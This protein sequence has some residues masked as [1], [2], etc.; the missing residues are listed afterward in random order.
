MMF[1][2]DDGAGPASTQ[3]GSQRQRRPS[4]TDARTFLKRRADPHHVPFALSACRDSNAASPPQAL[5]LAVVVMVVV[6]SQD[7]S[8]DDDDAGKQ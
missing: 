6:G 2:S 1:G 7:R 4:T 5:L 3:E 8:D